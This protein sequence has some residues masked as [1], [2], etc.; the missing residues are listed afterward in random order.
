M[1]SAESYCLVVVMINRYT[2]AT[3]PKE[4]TSS[5]SQIKRRRRRSQQERCRNTTSRLNK[6]STESSGRGEVQLSETKS[7]EASQ[8]QLVIL[9]SQHS[10]HRSDVLFSVKHLCTGEISVSEFSHYYV[11]TR[12]FQSQITAITAKIIVLI[13]V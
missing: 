2:A 10:P 1:G 8:L 6:R 3:T 12:N 7:E 5:S 9:W 13:L 11:R 4:E